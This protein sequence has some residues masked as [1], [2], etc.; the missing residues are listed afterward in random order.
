MYHNTC[1]LDACSYEMQ[2]N[3]A[4]VSDNIQLSGP[5]KCPVGWTH[6]LPVGNTT[7]KTYLKKDPVTS[8]YS[9][10]RTHNHLVRK[11]TLNHFRPVWLN[12][13]VFVYELSSCGFKSRCCHLNFT[14][15]A[16]FKQGVPW[17]SGNYRVWIQSEMRDRIR[18]YSHPVTTCDNNK[19]FL[20]YDLWLLS[21]FCS[22]RT[23][24][25]FFSR[26]VFSL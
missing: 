23:L 21:F 13:W 1:F 12:G 3:N 17:H 26:K 2:K 8:D 24:S 18:T 10:I 7:M 22:I 4:D 5:S 11:Q 14:S 15:C 6:W 16:C 19:I 20:S 25:T 9:G